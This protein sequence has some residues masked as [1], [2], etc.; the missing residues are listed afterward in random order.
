MFFFRVEQKFFKNIQFLSYT[1][2]YEKMEKNTLYKQ[3][4]KFETK[5]F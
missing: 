1:Q 3:H 4:Y 2:K 5:Q